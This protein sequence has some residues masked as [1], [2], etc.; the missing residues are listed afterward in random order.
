M[1]KIGEITQEQLNKLQKSRNPKIIFKDLVG[2]NKTAKY[3][4]GDTCIDVDGIKPMDIIKKSFNGRDFY[5]I[6]VKQFNEDLV[7]A[8]SLYPVG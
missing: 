7:F 3:E 1:I 8:Y 4:I 5:Y 6:I 2:L